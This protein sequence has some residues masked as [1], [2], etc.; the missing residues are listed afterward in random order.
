VPVQRSLI[1]HV[2]LGLAEQLA[3]SVFWRRCS[4]SKCK[5]CIMVDARAVKRAGL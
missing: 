3:G 1:A 2:W 5:T 4:Y